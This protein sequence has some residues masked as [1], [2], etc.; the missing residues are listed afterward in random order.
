M[1]HQQTIVK[2]QQIIDYLADHAVF[3]PYVRYASSIDALTWPYASP[4]PVPEVEELVQT[5]LTD[6]GFRG[7]KL[8]G[9]LGTTDGKIISD[10]VACAIPPQYEVAY[11]L[12]VEGLTL[13]AQLQQKEG[14]E[15]AALIAAVVLLGAVIVAGG[16][17]T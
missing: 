11:H 9:W 1:S 16:D 14:R 13:A 12:A 8:G 6:A 4:P 10:A 15:T 17:G 5:L 7:L 3:G 2:Q